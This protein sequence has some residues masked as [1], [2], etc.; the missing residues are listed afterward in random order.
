MFYLDYYMFAPRDADE[1]H[2]QG[3]LLQDIGVSPRI[4]QGHIYAID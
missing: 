3:T 4:E 1:S 2:T